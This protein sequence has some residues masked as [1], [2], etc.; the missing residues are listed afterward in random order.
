MTA[1]NV[2]IVYPDA[3]GEPAVRVV[4]D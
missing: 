4:R 3:Y 1:G 2:L